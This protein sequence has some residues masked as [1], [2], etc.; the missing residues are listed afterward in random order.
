MEGTIPS[1]DDAD[2]V[3][4]RTARTVTATVAAATAAR[5]DHRNRTLITWPP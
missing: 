3:S 2:P 5:T 1:P 4:D